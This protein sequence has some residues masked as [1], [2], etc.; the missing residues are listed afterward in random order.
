MY[1]MATASAITAT[2]C[3]EGCVITMSTKRVPRLTDT[4]IHVAIMPA[5]A[6]VDGSARPTSNPSST[7]PDIQSGSQRTGFGFRPSSDVTS[8]RA[9]TRFRRLGL[10]SRSTTVFIASTD[11]MST[12]PVWD[13]SRT[14]NVACFTRSVAFAEYRGRA[15][16]R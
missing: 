12:S 1:S 4:F 9:A 7:A 5:L 16:E 11:R 3:G 6:P 15:F 8:V 10:L 14:E 2:A 13:L